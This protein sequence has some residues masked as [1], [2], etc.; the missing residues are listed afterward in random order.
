MG[1]NCIN[2]SKK[3]LSVDIPAYR[4]DILHEI[5]LVEDVAK[6]FGYENF[7]S[8]FPKSLTFGKKLKVSRFL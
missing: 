1:Y 5:D 8:D 3:K 6:G 2:K 4:A 7:E